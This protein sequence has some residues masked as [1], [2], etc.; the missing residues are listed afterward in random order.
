MSKNNSDLAWLEVDSQAS[1][2]RELPE[3]SRAYGDDP[4][5]QDAQPCSLPFRRIFPED[6]WLGSLPVRPL[7]PVSG[8]ETDLLISL[9][10]NPNN[11]DM[12]DF[13]RILM[14]LHA[15]PGGYINPAAGPDEQPE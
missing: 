1:P 12:E 9:S 14:E 8:A 13:R 11:A 4:I 15:G 3:P 2:V 6:F 5:N 7:P 10:V